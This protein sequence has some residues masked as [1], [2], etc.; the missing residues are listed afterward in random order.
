MALAGGQDV[1]L[2]A[3]HKDGVGGLLGDEALQAALAR[4]PLGLDDLAGGEGRG[5]DVADL[6]LVDEVGEGTQS[7][8]NVGVGV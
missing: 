1:V 2:D 6:A 8:L 4:Y 5:A 7:F 3:P